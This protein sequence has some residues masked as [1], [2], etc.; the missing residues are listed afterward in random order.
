MLDSLFLRQYEWKHSLATVERIF[1]FSQLETL[2]LE[3]GHWWRDILP[4]LRYVR[5]EQFPR[6][7][8]LEIMNIQETTSTSHSK[9]ISYLL[10]RLVAN[11]PRL[12]DLTTKNFQSL[13]FGVCHNRTSWRSASDLELY[14]LFIGISH[15]WAAE[16][17]SGCMRELE[18]VPPSFRLRWAWGISSQSW[19]HTIIE[20]AVGTE[21]LWIT[22]ASP[23]WIS[24]TW[25]VESP[26]IQ[27]F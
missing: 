15:P 6:L 20:F 1:D 18:G 25:S 10:G 24:L 8:K 19:Q 16:S 27:V 11:L 22:S 12:E 9:E 3:P 17:S 21:L 7:R 23:V 26:T 13:F 5:A 2:V 14:G 4:F